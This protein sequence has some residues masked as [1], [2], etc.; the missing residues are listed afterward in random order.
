MRPVS[1]DAINVCAFY[2]DLCNK[3]NA[4]PNLQFVDN[5]NTGGIQLLPI[6][7]EL[8]LSVF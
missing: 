7:A 4:V 1:I 5:T 2:Y 6:R 8:F 3:Y